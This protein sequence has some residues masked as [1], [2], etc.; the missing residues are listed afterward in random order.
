MS[1]GDGRGTGW[2]RDVIERLAMAAIKEQR[3]ARRWGIF[4]KLLLFLYLFGLLALY[5][6]GLWQE[7]ELH[8]GKHTALVNLTGVIA[9]GQ[10]AN[11]DDII[12]ALDSAFKAKGSKG[13][14]LRI[15]S[16]GGS[17]VQAGQIADEIRRL[18][19]QYPHKPLY[20]VVDD[21]CASGGYY[22]ASAADK[23]YVNKA[24]LVG[25]I[26]VL[27]NGFGFVDSLHKLGVERRL[28]TAGQHKGFLDPFSPVQPDDV[29]YVESMLDD[30]HQQFID[31][32]KQGR[33]ARLKND[34]QLFS[35]LMW[36]GDKAIKL[37]LADDYGSVGQVARD[38]IGARQVVDYT[39]K[40]GFLARVAD[41]IG[42]SMANLVLSRVEAPALR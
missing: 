20:A 35:G 37:G 21:L 30:I 42:S 17:P 6:P 9:A 14:I 11:A 34:P 19:K 10:P 36:T 12:E 26:G 22:V 33:G 16:P 5:S 38:V 41:R 8:T 3:R 15:N 23:I 1:D 7:S 29:K 24:S 2:E 31:V 40:Q 4:F 13:V 18:R 25:S 27:M 28:Y 39:V 32:V